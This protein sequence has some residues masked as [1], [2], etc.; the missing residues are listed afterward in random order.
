MSAS[1]A[2]LTAH[3]SLPTTY[4]A[5]AAKQASPQ[6]NL[7]R[8]A[9]W[10][11]QSELQEP[12]HD[13]TFDLPSAST[14]SL[15]GMRHHEMLQPHR[16]MVNVPASSHQH[17][18]ISD[19]LISQ[20]AVVSTGSN[21]NLPAGGFVRSRKEALDAYYMAKLPS[22]PSVSH[23]P[24]AFNSSGAKPA[25]AA[26]GAGQLQLVSASSVMAPGAEGETGHDVTVRR[27]SL[28]LPETKH[29]VRADAFSPGKP[30][31]KSQLS[32]MM[33][34]VAQ[35][36]SEVQGLQNQLSV[37]SRLGHKMGSSASSLADSDQ[38]VDE[39]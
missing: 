6:A 21:S 34:E 27:V 18:V 5:F 19:S 36:R 35:A 3:S 23:Q 13:D 1:P 38:V 9:S 33:E 2:K 12:P 8:N 15:P 14:A 16:A 4:A 17:V 22:L 31:L 7:F 26:S 39:V 32:K 25:G 28:M 24:A 30:G 10:G 29:D 20:G 37:H 11:R